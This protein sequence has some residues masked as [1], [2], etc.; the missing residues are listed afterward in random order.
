MEG[1][2][3]ETATDVA[4]N[5]P[6]RNTDTHIATNGAPTHAH[7]PTFAMLR[8]DLTLECSQRALEL[9]LQVAAARKLTAKTT[10]RWNYPMG[11]LVPVSATDDPCQLGCV[12]LPTNCSFDGSLLTIPP[13]CFLAF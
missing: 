11:K 5:A 12:Q 1:W 10:E 8:G 3:G 6:I 13:L 2:K 4:T 9:R 7:R